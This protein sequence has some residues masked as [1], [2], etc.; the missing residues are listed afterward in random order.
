MSWYH[1]EMVRA[2]QMLDEISGEIQRS[3]EEER[4]LLSFDEYIEIVQEEKER[5]LRDA[6]SYLRDMLDFFGTEE[7]ERPWGKDLRYRVFD[8][9]FLSTEEAQR[10]A[11]VAQEEVQHELRRAIGNFTREG[12]PNRVVLLHG[13][14]GSAKS[15]IAACLMRG[16][17]DYSARQ[18]GALYRYHWV[19]PK[20]ASVRGTIGFGGERPREE[21]PH[22]YAHL[23]DEELEARIFVEVRDHPLFL[24]PER[25]RLRLLTSLVGDE[26][27]IPRWL[28]HGS[29]CHKSQQIFIALLHGYGGDW[30]E[31]LRHV[32]IERYFISRRYRVGAVTLGPELSVDARER[33][34]T[35]DR[36]LGS[37]PTSL[38]SLSLFEVSGELVDAA[39]GLL[40]L[41]DL[42]KRPI[43][44]FKYLQ[45]TAETGEVALSSQALQINA[46]FL[47][48]G[49]ELHLRAF[50]E[51]PEFESFRGR[52][53]LIPVPYLRDHR[54]EQKIYD[55]QMGS[56]AE[57][58]IAPHA[59]AIAARFAVLTRLRRPEGAQLSESLR[60]AVSQ[61]SAWEKM[62]LYAGRSAE[63]GA[64][65]PPQELWPIVQELW[66]EWDAAPDYE[67][68][69]GASPREMRALLLDAA[70]DPKFD[71]LSPFAVL[72]ELDALC[73]RTND[74]A[75]LRIAAVPQ[76]FHDHADFRKRLRA[77]LFD[78][79]EDELRQASGLVEEGRY[80]DLLSRYVEQVSASVKGERV[81]NSVT[82]QIEPPDEH[83][84]REVERLLGSTEPSPLFRSRMLQRI[85]AWA[86]EHPEIPV[87]RSEVFRESLTK[88][89]QS[90]FEEKRSSLA[91]FCR[92]LA[93]AQAEQNSAERSQI[94]SALAI[95][96]ERFG[97]S[98]R[99]A[100]DAAG[101]LFAERYASVLKT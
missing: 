2:G 63:R 81:K 95:L 7:V 88:I 98:E 65:G 8:Q 39:G 80:D 25:A 79:I 38:Q 51:H 61:L 23:R 44:A 28:S 83:L 85:A 76:G 84:M 21:R 15:T 26:R 68:S 87:Q 30:K 37:L 52:F 97:Y 5:Q 24:I 89:R 91:H 43:D 77:W 33:Q 20:K 3:Y 11:L 31:V 36:N 86:I 41:S 45:M 57:G 50:R 55:R 67:A 70:Q 96:R 66:R 92:L 29:L 1:Q 42:L 75:F 27:R 71:Y 100:R 32:Q 19:F 34:V 47:A 99:A 14:N 40:E 18:E 90:V 6:A 60:K 9:S 73:E 10:E 48:S 22:S 16:L 93:E 59:T 13:P 74:Y 54:E 56:G 17:E 72:D 35:A 12:R 53:D 78:T 46:V 64:A 94:E 49:N 4:R 69:F 82:G 62:Q 58:R 101:R